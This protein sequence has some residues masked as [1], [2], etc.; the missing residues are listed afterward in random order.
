[1]SP[2]IRI[3]SA[4]LSVCSNFHTSPKLS[5]YWWDAITPGSS[6][7]SPI[8]FSTNSTSKSSNVDCKIA[9]EKIGSL[10]IKY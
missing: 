3:I 10:I 8:N 7:G 5:T 4:P 6:T 2:T 9:A 1:M